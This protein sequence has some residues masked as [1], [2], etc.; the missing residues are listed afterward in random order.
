MNDDEQN[1]ID[2]PPIAAGRFYPASE[3]NLRSSLE[4]LFN[5]E[6]GRE[7]FTQP[8]ALIV[9]HAGYVYSGRVAASAY[10][11]VPPQMKFSNIFIIATS[12]LHSFNGAAVYTSGDFITPLGRVTVNCSISAELTKRSDY[13]TIRPETHAGEHSIEV[14]LPFIQYYFTTKPAIVPVIIATTDFAAIR[15]IAEALRPWFNRDN[16]FVFSSDFS[17]YPAYDDAVAADAEAAGAIMTGKPGELLRVLKKYRNC[18]IPGMETVMCGWSA[19]AVLMCLTEEDDSIVYRHLMYRNSG[20][21]E[22]GDRKGVVGYHSFI[23]TGKTEETGTAASHTITA[24][25]REELFRMARASIS[26]GLKDSRYHYI[27]KNLMTDSLQKQMGAFV[28]I[29]KSGKLRGCIGRMTSTEPLIDLIA[30]MAFS[31]A[32]EDP[33]FPAVTEDELDEIELEISALTPLTRISGI[34]EIEIGRHG[35]YIRKGERSGVLLP[36]VAAERNWSVVQFL[37]HTSG[38]KAGLG[39]D[40]WKDADIFIF[41]TLILKEDRSLGTVG[42]KK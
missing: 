17:H 24:A 5:K 31:A 26:N 30:K 42:N 16:L 8:L 38:D 33:R 34:D 23:V 28:T 7:Q 2:R 11:S 19:A 37:E 4:E 20:D 10:A 6:A 13:F 29:Y 35:L 40:G 41:E 18:T 3:K 32:F 21:S 36:Q 12:H 9:P 14:Q 22:Y 25:E 15:S 39:K 1:L 27:R